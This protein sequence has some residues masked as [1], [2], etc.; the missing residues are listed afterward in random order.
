MDFHL[1]TI[2]QQLQTL[3]NKIMIDKLIVILLVCYSFNGFSQI[4]NEIILSYS[5][6]IE[7]VKEHHPLA[8][9]ADIQVNKGDAS[10]LYAKGAFDPKIY[11][12]IS[13]KKFKGKEYYSIINRGLK[14][15][16]WFGV[17]LKGGYEQNKG[18]FLNP[19]N[20]TPD[21]GLLYAGISVPIGRGL[22]IDERR[23][24]LSKAKLFQKASEQ[25]RT[26]ILNELVFMA[27]TAYWKWFKTYN[28]FLVYSDA[29][30]LANE[31]LEA[32]KFSA[33]IGDVP[34]IDTLE[35]GIQVQNRLLGLQQAELDYKNASALLSIYI[36]QDGIIPLEIAKNTV[37]T[38]IDNTSMEITNDI[39]YSEI[40]SLINNHPAL[41]K[42]R[43]NI[44]QLEIDKRLKRNQLLP[45]LNLKY[46]PIAEYVGGESLNNFNLNNYT[47][48]MT[49]QTPIFLR[50]ERGALKLME[51][52]I[53]EY[54]LQLINKQE[55]LKYKI[56]S[57]WNQ[58]NTII[59][60]INLYAQT[61]D[62]TRRLL[63]GEQRLFDLGE[64]SLFKL[65]ARE[66]KFIKTQ[67]KYIELLMLN[68]TTALSV[69]YAIGE[70]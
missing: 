53:Q 33:N 45:T 39:L 22:F 29:Y 52:K 12:D 10:L 57:K 58:W 63:E 38:P 28:A 3:Q 34:A 68:K 67:L 11:A 25:E 21:N 47:W 20:T 2:K 41:N 5:D 24:E 30:R 15:P 66:V 7:I 56:V 8:K 31:R 36:W 64:S 60:Q 27:G 59:A 69:K 62:D 42:S 51:L 50:K 13:Q 1:T 18:V 55:I 35:A 46:N 17:E 32:V 37:P 23:A 4:N 65:N 48:G 6:F 19:E 70:F 26:L 61:V 14:I 54:S 9:Q 16:T 40:D 43:I 49:F 44:S